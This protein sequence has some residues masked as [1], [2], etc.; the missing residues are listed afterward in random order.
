MLRGLRFFERGIKSREPKLNDKLPYSWGPV[1]ITI[2]I[3]FLHFHF[4]MILE[5]LSL[6]TFS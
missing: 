1:C 6:F 5:K 2:K 4:K 3:T